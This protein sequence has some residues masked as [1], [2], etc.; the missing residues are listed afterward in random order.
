MCLYISTYLSNVQIFQLQAESI[1]HA[2]VML[3]LIYVS[4]CSSWGVIEMT[5]LYKTEFKRSN[6][7]FTIYSYICIFSECILRKKHVIMRNTVTKIFDQMELLRMPWN[8]NYRPYTRAP[9]WQ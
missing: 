6:F 7:N 5:P 4:V 3:S 2:N 1:I 8:T 9:S